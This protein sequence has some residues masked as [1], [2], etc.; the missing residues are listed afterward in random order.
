LS[1]DTRTKALLETAIGTTEHLHKEV[2]L[3]IHG[4][5]Q[6]TNTLTDTMQRGLEVKIAE[7]KGLVQCGRTG[8]G[9]DAAKARKFGPDYIMDRVTV[10]VRDR[11]RAQLL[12]ALGEIHILDHRHAGP[13][14]RLL[15]RIPKGATYEETI[16]ALE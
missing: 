2:G 3:M 1:V 14:H 4:E 11:S 8:I 9:M 15:H 16:E 5:T 10:P 13:D 12:D 7:V 6:R